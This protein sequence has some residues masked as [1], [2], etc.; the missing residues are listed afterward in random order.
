MLLLQCFSLVI[1]E[2]RLGCT[3]VERGQGQARGKATLV[4]I[5]LFFAAFI[6]VW[7]LSL[8]SQP[9]G[10]QGR[11]AGQECRVCLQKGHTHREG[12]REREGVRHS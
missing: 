2:K 5:G 10:R 11:S 8:C 1:S 12:E 6:V 4:A 9:T 7:L 3:R